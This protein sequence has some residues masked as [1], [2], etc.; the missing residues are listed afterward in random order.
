MIFVMVINF[1]I[2]NNL[3]EFLNKNCHLKRRFAS[4][5]AADDCENVR[6]I[7]NTS[8]TWS[9]PSMIHSI[10]HNSLYSLRLL[11]SLF[12]LEPVFSQVAALSKINS[13]FSQSW[14]LFKQIRVLLN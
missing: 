13:F 3:S 8:H 12:S 1:I 11:K 9:I 5:H 2:E 10:L 14:A 4:T 6:M 7:H